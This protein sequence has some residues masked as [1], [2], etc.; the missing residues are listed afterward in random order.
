MIG[1]TLEVGFL[2][3]GRGVDRRGGRQEYG[4]EECDGWDLGAMHGASPSLEAGMGTLKTVRL[5]AD[6]AVDC[7]RP[8]VSRRQLASAWENGLP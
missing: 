6:S 7:Q 2:G 3:L 8:T 4:C 1:A 5:C